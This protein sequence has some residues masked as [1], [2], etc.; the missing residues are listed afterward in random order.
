MV[1][2]RAARTS[3]YRFPFAV[4]QKRSYSNGESGEEMGASEEILASF[5]AALSKDG[6]FESAFIDRLAALIRTGTLDKAKLRKLI[7]EASP[8]ANK[9]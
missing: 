9:D 7:E 2:D 4:S 1:D 6:L 3:G 5:S 8:S